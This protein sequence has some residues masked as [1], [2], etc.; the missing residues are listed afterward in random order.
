MRRILFLAALGLAT[1]PGAASALTITY[2]NG[3]ETVKAGTII[4]VRWT[5]ST[6]TTTINLSVLRDGK[7]VV[8]A[9]KLYAT[10][11]KSGWHASW[12]V[13]DTLTHG[14]GYK[15]RL[16]D[17]RT[18]KSDQSN[19]GFT[20][21]GETKLPDL[22]VAGTSDL[23]DST[24]SR[25]LKDRMWVK[26]GNQGKAEAKNIRVNIYFWGLET[27]AGKTSGKI[28]YE[29]AMTIAALKPGAVTTLRPY[30]PGLAPKAPTC[31][32]VRIDPLK[33]I[34][35]SKEDNNSTGR[36]WAVYPDAFLRAFSF[37]AMP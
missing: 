8:P 12:R 31:W 3:G 15:I 1:V 20:I 33:R 27:T 16:E 11:T 32:G 10:G 29:R 26:V 9:Q 35:E 7:T 6:P 22:Y 21:D 25:P 34:A 4:E 30:D 23:T 37:E 17:P 28:Y 18:G 2:P 24:D 13:P 5:T 36:L 19:A 14:G